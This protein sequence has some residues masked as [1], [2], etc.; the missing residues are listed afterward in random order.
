M[1]TT[2]LATVPGNEACETFLPETVAQGDGQ[3]GPFRATIHPMSRTYEEDGPWLQA[4]RLTVLLVRRRDRATSS[5][6]PFVREAGAKPGT[7]VARR[8]ATSATDASVIPVG[9]LSP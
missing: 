5:V 6:D 4:T 9:L 7:L 3:A 8:L 2:P 1:A